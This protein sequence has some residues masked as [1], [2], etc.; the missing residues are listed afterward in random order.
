V[1]GAG[2]ELLDFGPLATL[3]H[4]IKGRSQKTE[5]IR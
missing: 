4:R 1:A 3:S 5:L 2:A